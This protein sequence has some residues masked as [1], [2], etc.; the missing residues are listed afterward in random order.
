MGTGR[1]IRV[2]VFLLFAL[3]AAHLCWSQVP[4][5]S[6]NAAQ[7]NTK[8]A[9]RDPLGRDTPYSCVV[10][11]L[12]AAERGESA[13]AAEYLE[14]ESSADP[15]ELVRQLLALLNL[16]R[17]VNLESLSKAPEG[18]LQDGLSAGRERVGV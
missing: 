4:G 9:P 5:L 6:T 13:R 7:A 1:N 12:R 11:F 2:S 18:E 15:A 10:G 17:V 8:P 16:E 3:A 14:A